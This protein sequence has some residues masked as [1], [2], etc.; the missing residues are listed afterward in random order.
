MRVAFLSMQQ[1]FLDALNRQQTDLSRVQEQVATGKRFTRAGQDP[2]AATQALGLDSAIAVN[3]QYLRNS[4]Q[5]G[6]PPGP[7]RE[8]PGAGGRGAAAGA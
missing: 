4:G 2:V 8:R 1:A 6:Q 3:A 7:Q 5:A